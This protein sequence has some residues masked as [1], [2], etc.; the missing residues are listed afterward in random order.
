MTEMREMEIDCL[1]IPP[2]FAYWTLEEYDY[3]PEEVSEG[4]KYDVWSVNL[5][6]PG[7]DTLSKWV[8]DLSDDTI[9]AAAKYLMGRYVSR[10][11][12]IA[13]EE[14]PVSLFRTP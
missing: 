10:N 7:T 2:E 12:A 8:Y 3:H 14:G 9:V 13:L 11:R 4:A 6:E 1:P 5:V